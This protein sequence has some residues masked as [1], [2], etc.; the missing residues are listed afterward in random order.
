MNSQSKKW[1]IIGILMTFVLVVMIQQP[2]SVNTNASVSKEIPQYN[3]DIEYKEK[4]QL[5]I[6]KMEL[7][8]V[9]LTGKQLNEIYFHLFPNAFQNW[10][11]EKENKP[12]SAGSIQ[13]K[14]ALI[15]GTEVFA[16]Q[17]ETL[18]KL[19]FPKPLQQ[20][21]N[22]YVELEFTLKLPQK[23]FRLS[24]VNQTVF[25]AQWY[26][27]L[28]VYDEK[29]WHLDPYTTTGDPFYS[30]VANF[31]VKLKFPKGYQ[32]I[33]SAEEPL[34]D[35]RTQEKLFLSQKKVRDFAIVLTKEYEAIR[36]QS[37]SGI[38]TNLWYLN[39]QQE[40]APTLVGGAVEAMNF[41]EEYFGEYPMKEVDIVLGNSSY[42]VAGM[43]YPGL[44][45]SD[46]LTQSK[47][48]IGPAL[49]VV[50]HELAHQWWYGTV[51]ND[52]IKEPW[53][54]EGLT[55][56]S[57][58]LFSEKVLHKDMSSLMKRI[59]NITD[60]MAKSSNITV[61]DSIYKYGD[62]YGAFVY[63]RPAAML[64]ELRDKVGE[65]KMKQIMQTYYQTYQF[66]TANT[67]DFIKIV[68]QVVKKDMSSFFEE[69]L[70][71]KV[72]NQ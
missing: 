67:E 22:T 6:G 64:W 10:K 14:S 54:D 72:Q 57:E 3:I 12:E 61:V 49:N 70:L 28:A 47:D 66:K 13:I 29:G 55:S 36:T 5:V 41:Y 7:K 30:E 25:L 18:L 20:S 33:S 68:N 32:V 35:Q 53:L 24:A 15:D 4:E 60:Q 40:V 45:T 63:A 17:N 19:N 21:K 46:P 59:K 48:K 16:H 37:K 1:F 8:Y 65:E 58:Y 39:G 52:Q 56:F 2:V 38:K 27:M 71:I 42:G 50:A 43:E 11:W 62:Q 69:W 23:G 31:D 26:P 34:Q 9:N 44:V 51:G